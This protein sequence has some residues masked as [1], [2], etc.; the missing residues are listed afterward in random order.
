MAIQKIVYH[1]SPQQ[2]LKKLEPC[3]STNL[4]KWVYA[5]RD[6]NIA[7]LFLGRFLGDLSC[8][9]GR[10]NGETGLPFICERFKGAFE[11]RYNLSGSIYFLDGS[12]FVETKTSWKEEVVCPYE[13]I[14]IDEEKIENVGNYIHTIARKGQIIMVR[15]PKKICGIPEDDRDLV[16]KASRWIQEG[17]IG[18]RDDI[19][20]Y[21]P[22][23]LDRVLKEVNSKQK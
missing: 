6:K 9:I 13:V 20:R 17:R 11:K 8:Q 5:T 3:E 7:A 22:N 23:L 18:I 16:M 15:Y 4:S 14:P 2:G 21:H 12:S 1:A 19:K 10:D